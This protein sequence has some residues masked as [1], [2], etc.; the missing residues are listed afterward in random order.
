M[1][2]HRIAPYVHLFLEVVVNPGLDL[3]QRVRLRLLVPP[4]GSTI[5]RAVVLWGREVTHTNLN[6][7][8]NIKIIEIT[9]KMFENKMNIILGI[10]QYKLGE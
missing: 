3:G 8:K 6:L 10:S 2:S 5:T 9:L 1:P 7:E 4:R